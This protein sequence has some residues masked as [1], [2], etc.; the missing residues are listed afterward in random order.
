MVAAPYD[1]SRIPDD[2]RFS[3]DRL[4]EDLSGRGVDA[5]SLPTSES[6]AYTVAMQAHP[7]D[8]V[9]ILSNG[10]FDGL[11]GKLLERLQQ[12]FGGT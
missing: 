4:V 3:S 7:R 2:E 10:G 8:V 1:Q 12:R 9:A 11:H 6:I 5:L